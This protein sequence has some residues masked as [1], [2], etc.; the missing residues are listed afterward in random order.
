MDDSPFAAVF[1]KLDAVKDAMSVKRAFG[2]AYEMDGIRVIPVAAVRG[3][4][5]GGGG[6]GDTPDAAGQGSGAGMGFGLHV[7]PVGVYVVKDATVTWSPAMD[8][9]RIVLGFQLVGIVGI[10]SIRRVLMHRRH[11]HH[12]DRGQAARR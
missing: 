9:T 8:V 2:D 11:H 12:H 4:G 7:R 10:L 5:G 1:S 3:G 6:V